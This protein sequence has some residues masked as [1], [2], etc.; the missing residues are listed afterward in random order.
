MRENI[1]ELSGSV[2]FFVFQK[3]ISSIII[4]VF[5]HP[6]AIILIFKFIYKYFININCRLTEL[7]TTFNTYNPKPISIKIVLGLIYKL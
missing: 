1:T 4:N 7:L 2:N 6:Q 3:F 5:S